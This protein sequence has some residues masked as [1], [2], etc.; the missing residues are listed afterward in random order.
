ME[1]LTLEELVEQLR[2]DQQ[3]IVDRIRPLMKHPDMVS[4]GLVDGVGANEAR[5]NIMLSLR[6]GEDARLRLGKVNQAMQGGVSILDR[7][8]ALRARADNLEGLFSGST[9]LTE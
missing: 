9:P 5:A 8:D 6:H 4:K 2:T 3:A 7:P 1:E